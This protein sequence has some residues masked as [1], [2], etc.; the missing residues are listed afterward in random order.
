MLSLSMGAYPLTTRQILCAMGYQLG[1][2]PD[3]C[4]ALPAENVLWFI[5][6]P[7]VLLA[8]GVGASLAVSGVVM[9]GVFRNPLADP[10]LVGT[11]SGGMLAAALA[12][13]LGW[14]VSAG[15]LG[16]YGLS[17]FAF[18]G[19]MLAMFLVFYLAEAGGRLAISTLLLAGIA[20]NALSGALTS[21]IMY[22]SDDA[23][24]RGIVFWTLG[25]LGGASWRMLLVFLPL[26]MLPLLFIFRVARSLDGYALGDHDAFSLGVNVR[27]L[28][29]LLI[30]LVT[31]SVATGVA[32]V[33][34]IGFVGLVI[35]H[36][37]RLLFGGLHRR[38]IVA[39]GVLG[40]LLLTLADL[41]CRT[42]VVPAELPVGI[43]T[44]MMG[45]PLFISLL[46]RRKKRQWNYV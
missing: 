44:A 39:A 21:L 24:L 25:S 9:Q 36:M 14:D 41:L 23:Q 19:A 8:M 33:G 30:L 43:L 12:I 31:L 32:F 37:A 1:L 13:L 28:R 40:A 11:S 45:V 34:I 2:L 22:L 3:R 16:Y 42:M 15:V 5:R 7:R 29:F 17:F 4:A 20:I 26:G 46:L 27:R 10:G 35:P 38:L 18:L 6:L